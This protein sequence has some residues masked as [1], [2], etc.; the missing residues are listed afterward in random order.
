MNVG[1]K[2]FTFDSTKDV[3]TQLDLAT[4]ATLATYSIGIGPVL[5]Q[6][7]LAFQSSNVGFLTSAL[8]PTTLDPVNDLYRFDLSTGTSV[9]LG[10]TADTLEALA[11]SSA[12]TLYGLG[13]L[14]GNLYTIDPTNG[15]MTLVG[16]VGISVGSPTGG[17][18]FGPDGTLYATLDDKLYTLNPSSGLA[19]A[20]GSSDPTIYTGF[21][22]ISGLAFAPAVP[23]PAS[24]VSLFIGMAIVGLYARHVRG[25]GKASRDSRRN[26]RE[27]DRGA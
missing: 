4:G 14:D 26:K 27:R 20:V 5:G 11:F 7:G 8:D 18:T 22:S 10:H 23:E 19:T 12:G 6:G 9:L 2:L 24:S 3:V 16:N 15:S 13:K 1:G 21:N 25:S 17:L